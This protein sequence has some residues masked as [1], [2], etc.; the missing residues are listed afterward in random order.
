L[1]GVEERP[2]S[3][4]VPDQALRLYWVATP[5]RRMPEFTQFDS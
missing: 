4:D 3:L 5:M 2:A 1:N